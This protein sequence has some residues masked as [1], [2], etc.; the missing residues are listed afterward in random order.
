MRVSFSCFALATALLASTAAA[1]SSTQTQRATCSTSKPTS[2][3]SSSTVSSSSTPAP[4]PE[5]A[6]TA[7]PKFPAKF[8]NPIKPN[9]GSD[10]WVIYSKKKDTWYLAKSAGGGVQITATRD[11]AWFDS[12]KNGTSVWKAPKTMHNLWAPELHHID[13]NWYIYAALDDGKNANHRMYVLKGS[14][15]NDP[16]KPFKL[17]GKITSPDDNWAIDGTVFQYTYGNRTKPDLYFIWSGWPKKDAGFPQN[18]Y[19][20][21]MCSPTKICGNR[22]LLHTPNA[23][24]QKSGGKGVNEGPEMLH[25]KFKDS[26]GKTKERWFLTYSAAGSWTDDYSLGLMGLDGGKDPMN[27]KNW[28]SI[29]DRPVFWKNPEQK[30][31]GP[32]HASFTTDRKGDNYIVYHAV[33]KSGNGWTNRTMRAEKFKWN[34]DG[35]PWFP[36]PSKLGTQLPHPQ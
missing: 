29:D 28:W 7:P 24:W 2:S 35:S 6:S 16:T 30:V 4:A 23:A 26:D 14:D 1:K 34:K 27:P 32:G 9:T 12:D 25:H 31:W 20:A 11:L 3:S 8:T 13:G 36:R 10:P 21:K 5:P 33:S 17:V 18:L 22:A 15:P 19:I